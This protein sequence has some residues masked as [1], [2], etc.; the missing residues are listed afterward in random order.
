MAD[1]ARP[2]P[3]WVQGCQVLQAKFNGL[4]HVLMRLGLVASTMQ[5]VLEL[6]TVL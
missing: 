3:P 5:N 4:V 1:P 2:Q 6:F